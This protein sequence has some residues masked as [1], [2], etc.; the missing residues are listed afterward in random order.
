MFIGVVFFIS[1]CA[2]D[3]QDGDGEYDHYYGHLLGEFSNLVEG[4]SAQVYL[5]D[6]KTVYL[7]NFRGEN[8]DFETDSKFKYTT[9]KPIIIPV[10]SHIFM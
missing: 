7:R 3:Y 4:L 9:I 10:F 5:A 8:V 6:R 2:N 1:A